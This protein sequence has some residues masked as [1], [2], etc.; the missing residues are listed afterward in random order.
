MWIKTQLIIFSIAFLMYCSPKHF[1]ELV[2][3]SGTSDELL[4]AFGSCNKQQLDQSYWNQIAVHKPYAWIWLGD[5]VYAD[6]D[7]MRKLHQMYKAQKRNTYYRSFADSCMILGIWDDHDYGL[8]DGG[9]NFSAKAESKVALFD[10]LDVPDN[11]PSRNREGAYQSYELKHHG[12]ILKV[13]LL[14]TRYFRDELVPDLSGNNRYLKASE[15]S[16]LGEEQ[17]IWLEEELK[18][19]KA[20]FH[21]LATGI[22]LIPSQHGFEK[23]G[24][25]PKERAK[26]IHLLEKYNPPG[27]I[28]I[29]GD[30]H[31]AEISQLE[32]SMKQ[33]KLTEITSSG[34]THSYEQNSTQKEKN[35]YRIGELYSEKNYGLL[36]FKNEPEKTI[37]IQLWGM[38]NNMLTEM[39]LDF[40][41]IK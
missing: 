32:T 5:I 28:L 30:R 18:H 7:D 19:S 8:N 13:L 2:Y 17:W 20:D 1:R 12:I 4:I 15:G 35:D 22:Q 16:I 36:S 33:G 38:R 29:S 27:V 9:K 21:I 41:T 34:L 40:Q 25:F 39:R 31:I 6:T 37:R 14:D 23:W 26:I 3:E 24:N 10:F 11:N